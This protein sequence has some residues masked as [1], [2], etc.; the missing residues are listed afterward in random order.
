MFGASVNDWA[1]EVDSVTTQLGSSAL[2]TCR[3]P[4]HVRPYVD[5][6]DWLH[7]LDHSGESGGGGGGGGGVG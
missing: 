3:V 4:P 7:D 5:V 2:F 1:L 6:V